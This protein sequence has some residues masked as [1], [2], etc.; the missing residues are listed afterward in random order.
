MVVRGA[1]YQDKETGAI[2]NYQEIASE[3][4]AMQQCCSEFDDYDVEDVI[5]EYYSEIEAS[6]VE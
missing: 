2:K 3:L 5:E 4:I 1:K 6:E